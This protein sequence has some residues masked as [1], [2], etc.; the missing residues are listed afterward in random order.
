M[1]LA[2]SDRL[3]VGTFNRRVVSVHADKEK[4]RE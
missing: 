2:E 3:V 1:D 4:V